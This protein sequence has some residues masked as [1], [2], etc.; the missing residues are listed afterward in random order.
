MF[1]AGDRAQSRFFSDG[2]YERALEPKEIPVIEVPA[3]EGS[4]GWLEPAADDAYMSVSR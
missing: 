1:I 3:E 4:K 2:A